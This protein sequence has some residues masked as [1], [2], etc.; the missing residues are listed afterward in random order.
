VVGAGGAKK[1]QVAEMVARMLKL[2]T[3]PHPY[4]AADGVAVALTHIIRA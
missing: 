4:D 3:A 1:Q 2:K